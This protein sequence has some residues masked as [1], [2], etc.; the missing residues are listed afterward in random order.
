MLRQVRAAACVAAVA[1]AATTATASAAAWQELPSQSPDPTSNELAGASSIPGGNTWWA[2]GQTQAGTLI[3]RARQTGLTLV[4]GP[5]PGR[6]ARLDAVSAVSGS[7]AWAVGGYTRSD[8]RPHALILHW[9]GGSWQI[10]PS[11]DVPGAATALGVELTG[12]LALSRSDVWAVGFR[13][14][15]ADVAETLAEHWNGRRWRIV[16]SQDPLDLEHRTNDALAAICRVPGT[17]QLWA[18]GANGL[19]GRPLVE[20]WTG[21]TWAAV[22]V[23][24]ATLPKHGIGVHL[25]GVAA[26]KRFVVA[27]GTFDNQANGHTIPIALVRTRAGWK[28]GHPVHGAGSAYFKAVT[29]VPGRS[30]FWAVG[31][32][33]T[34]TEVDAPFAERWDVTSWARSPITNIDPSQTSELDGI[35]ATGDGS[36][37]AVGL[38]ETSGQELTLAELRR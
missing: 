13:A 33:V 9:D 7:N 30:A 34:P 1:V 6:F 19:V 12:V 16:P 20:H 36:V 32:E 2:V 35:R 17:H 31:A 26:S 22:R 11:P 28:V 4:A 5:S 38:T 10:S 21:T 18:V 23:P 8:G 24:I 27:V 14:P 15:R 29:H 37:L 25:N 3:E